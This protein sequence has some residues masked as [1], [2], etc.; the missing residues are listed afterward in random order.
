M[1]RYSSDI[2]VILYEEDVSR[3]FANAK[4]PKEA[5]L[6]AIFWIT[7]ARP[8]EALELKREN[9]H[10]S[11]GT[12]KIRLATKKLGK[13]NEFILRERTLEF[14]VPDGYG[15]NPYLECIIRYATASP[16]TGFILPY[17]TR[18]AEKIINR[19]GMESLGKLISPY[20]FR[21]SVLSHHA[22]KGMNTMDLMA[23]KG[24]KSIGSVAPYLHAKP[25]V[26]KAKDLERARL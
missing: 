8:S 5:Y 20:H 25:F 14:E 3:M 23:F 12:L 21:H 2:S 15:T 6:V 18:W 17:T 11:D 19:L 4:S 22:S 9:F 26:V 13:T 24:A 10:L 16:D 7:G 1:P